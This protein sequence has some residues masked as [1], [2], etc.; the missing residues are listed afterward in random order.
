M[1]DKIAARK[2]LALERGYTDKQW[3]QTGFKRALKPYQPASERQLGYRQELFYQFVLSMPPHWKLSNLNYRWVRA[4]QK[5]DPDSMFSYGAELLPLSLIKNFLNFY[6]ATSKGKLFDKPTIN[7]VQ[8]ACNCVTT[9]LHR[10]V[11][12]KYPHDDLKDLYYV[13]EPF[14]ADLQSL[15]LLVRY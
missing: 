4:D 10:K 6:I 11:G 14:T 5:R 1:A 13:C 3:R 8:N 7:T 12:K 2:Q 9:S 15:R